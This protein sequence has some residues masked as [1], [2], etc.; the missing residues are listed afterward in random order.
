MT[1]KDTITMTDATTA[2][3]REAT[4]QHLRATV[5]ANAIRAAQAITAAADRLGVAELLRAAVLVAELEAL[6]ADDTDDDPSE[7]SGTG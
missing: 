4:L 2:Q 1:A 5:P 7:P 6:A 3:R